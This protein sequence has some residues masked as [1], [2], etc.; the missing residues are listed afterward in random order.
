MIKL[1]VAYWV[2]RDLH[3]MQNLQGRYC[4]SILKMSSPRAKEG[5]T[6]SHSSQ[7]VKARSE[8]DFFK[9]P[10]FFLKFYYGSLSMKIS[11]IKKIFQK[12]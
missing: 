8:S 12:I 6:R 4:Y 2:I 5:Y 11:L 1:C 10:N 3:F 9:P 7:G